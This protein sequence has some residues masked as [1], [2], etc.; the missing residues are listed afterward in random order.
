MNDDPRR[1]YIYGIT[2]EDDTM[3]VWYFSRSHSAKSPEFKFMEDCWTYIRVMLSLMFATEEEL[4]YDPTIQRRLDP[5]TNRV[6]FVYEVDGHYYKTQKAIFDHRSLCITGRATRVWEVIEVASFDKLQPLE[7]SHTMVLKD[8]W[9]DAGLMTEGDIQR[10]IFAD[11]EKIADALQ[12]GVEPKGFV[13]MDDESKQMLR[14]CLLAQDWHRYFLTLVCEWQGM[15]SKEVAEAAEP[16]STLF[17]APPTTEKPFNHRHCLKRQSRVVFKQVCVALHDVSKLGD[18]MTVL[19]SC[20]FALQL[21]FLAGWVH[22]DISSGNLYWFEG[23]NGEVRGILADLEY[24]KR[25]R[26]SDG[27]GSPDPK[28]VRMTVYIYRSEGSLT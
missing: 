15:T 11:L 21:M 14:K 23:N 1:M 3:A 27:K 7:G 13:G 25:F 2:I 18:A 12:A 20:V 24:A 4:G 9:L 6:C 22:R 28:T 16:D 8:V 26:P 10:E 5:E 17:G 19:L